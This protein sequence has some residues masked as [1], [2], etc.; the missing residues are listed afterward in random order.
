[1]GKRDRQESRLTLIKS[2]SNSV[3]SRAIKQFNLTRRQFAFQICPLRCTLY[4]QVFNKL[5]NTNVPIVNTQNISVTLSTG[6][7][8]VVTAEKFGCQMFWICELS[9]TR[10][11]N[12]NSFEENTGINGVKL[13]GLTRKKMIMNKAYG[14]LLTRLKSLFFYFMKQNIL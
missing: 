14:G 13:I 4:L 9:D 8:E 6:K 11:F 7:K 12:L 5:A 2:R 1:M 10:S 3:P